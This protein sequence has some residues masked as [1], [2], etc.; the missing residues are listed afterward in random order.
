MNSLMRWT[1][2]LALLA[3]W[4]GANQ[5]ALAQVYSLDED[6]DTGDFGGA[7][8]YSTL[9]IHAD[10]TCLWESQSVLTRAMAEQQVRM[11]ERFQK[12]SEAQEAG[13]NPAQPGVSATN[14]VKPFT[15]DELAK[16]LTETMN[17]R[18]DESGAPG[19]TNSVTVKKDSV[20]ITTT[21]S[22]ATVEEMLREDS[23]A[24]NQSG[25][26]LQNVRFETDTNGLLRVTLTP[27]SGTR[28]YLKNMRPEWKLS[29]MKSE[30]K[31]VFPGKVISSGL[32]AM[33]TNA[34][35]LA[36]DAQH[37]ESL[38]TLAK[39]YDAPTVITAEAGGIKLAQP[40]DSKQLSRSRRQAQTGTEDL[41][42]TNTEPGF[43][44]EA[45][46]I[47]TTMRYLFPGGEDYLKQNG[48]F[49]NS[50]TGTVVNANLFAPK[51]RTL[52]S[53]SGVR[54]VKAVDDQGRSV[55]AEAGDDDTSEVQERSGNSSDADAMA[56]QLRLLLPQP[57]AQSIAG[58]SAEAIAVTAGSWQEM[59]LT[60]L[61]Q[62]ATNE[63]DLAAVLPGA[64]IVITKLTFRNNQFSLQARLEGPPAVRRLELR[65]KIPGNDDFNTYSSERHFSLKG[66][67]ATRQMTIQGFGG[68][69]QDASAL[70]SVV[71]L[72]RNP[73]D[74]RRERVI[75]ELKSLDLL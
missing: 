17:E 75:F 63:L 32:P 13:E 33:A 26:Y 72:V 45:Q 7:E 30:L 74:L 8:Q 10:G 37:D 3:A 27:Q 12:M 21:H 31:L 68:G 16:K 29:G 59:T 62:N 50:Q 14:E 36:V 70:A 71:L 40:L 48:D 2:A 4:T 47:T 56:I 28:R 52:L 57:D 73:Q 69:D 24:W 66:Q 9:T 41:P 49:M 53:V 15:D 11:M 51:G 18:A 60:N 35:W 44:A 64:K 25:L 6:V 34:T 54:V 61:Q 43:V 46:S 38:D 39:L 67:Q 5:K 20:L 65:A 19:G 58:I 23:A 22:F 42:V 55:V 1:L